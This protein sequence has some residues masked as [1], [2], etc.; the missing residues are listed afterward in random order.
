M[1]LSVKSPLDGKEIKT[2]ET[3]DD[4][5]LQSKIKKVQEAQKSWQELSLKARGEEIL[6]LAD[7]V[8][9]NAEEIAEIINQESGKT[10]TEAKGEV[11]NF[12]ST[13]RSTVEKV[14]DGFEDFK[15]ME[16][17]KNPIPVGVVGLITSF[18]FPL[19][20]AGWN[21]AP[22]LLAGNAVIWKPSEKTPLTALKIEELFSNDLLQIAIGQVE[23]GKALVENEDVGMIT[24]TGS[25]AMGNSIVASLENK[26][27]N[28]VQP[29]IEAGGNN[30]VI[31]SANN[32]T[33]NLQFAV[34]A[35]A[36]SFLG[37]A[38][39]RCTN[40]R[41]LFVAS[42]VFDEVIDLFKA[43]MIEFDPNTP[44][45]DEAALET[46]E[47]ACANADELIGGGKI[48]GLYVNPALA[49][50]NSQTEVM[51]HECFGPLLYIVKY[52]DFAD[53]LAM[54]N[55][56]ENAGL[57]NGIYT[58][59]QKDVDGF[60][61]ANKAGHGVVNSPTGTGT[62]AF[63][64]GFGGNKESGIGEILNQ[65]E[66]LRSF[67]VGYNRLAVNSEIELKA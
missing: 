57:V 67:V 31:I 2:I 42:K 65:E 46:F 39:Q 58:E 61:A 4:K 6:K 7:S 38:G 54:Q 37:T 47:D 23:I 41:R 19:A 33:K 18:N 60:V 8:E 48:E 21:I 24:A 29:I 3:D 28:K 40:T 55:A 51:K 9:K 22:A 20:V 44:L 17:Y 64:M 50:M 25:V 26:K 11:G 15:G 14:V 30:G 10:L 35:I 12:I 66:P 43:K 63:G 45:I 52:D 34:D 49:I 32:S 27:G 53:A 13:L 59:S 1:T 62:P 56:P 5:T 36:S 16:R